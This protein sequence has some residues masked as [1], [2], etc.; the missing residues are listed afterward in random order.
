MTALQLIYKAIKGYDD[1]TNYA[2]YGINDLDDVTAIITDCVRNG[3]GIKPIEYQY[4]TDGTETI[5]D[6]YI[7]IPLPEALTEDDQILS[8]S[9]EGY[10]KTLVSDGALLLLLPE[11]FSGEV[12]VTYMPKVTAFT[13]TA[14]VLPI[15]DDAA[16]TV[17]KWGL[18]ELLALRHRPSFAD[19]MADKYKQAKRNWKGRDYV[20]TEVQDYYG[21]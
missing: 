11:G 17:A 6:D 15:S 9:Y 5:A 20:Y 12:I 7:Q 2:K 13:T 19:R 16:N 4:E 21:I 3:I 10:K 14:D 18:A 8:V 1:Y